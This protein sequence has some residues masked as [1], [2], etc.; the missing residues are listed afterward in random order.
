MCRF[1]FFLIFAVCLLSVPSA[2]AQVGCK[3]VRMQEKQCQSFGCSDKVF[4]KQCGVLAGEKRCVDFCESVPCCG[5]NY[6]SACDWGSCLIEDGFDV[7]QVRKSEIAFVPDGAGGWRA[8]IRCKRQAGR[9]S[10]EGVS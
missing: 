6:M 10:G 8:T 2:S 9:E 5:M 3:E 1:R 4:L 7:W